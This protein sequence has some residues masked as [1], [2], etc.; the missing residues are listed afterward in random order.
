MN[1]IGNQGNGNRAAAQ[2]GFGLIELMVALLLG[3]IIAGGVVQVFYSTN[4]AYR[5]QQAL[6]LFDG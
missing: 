5:S 4:Q 1:G 2:R 6:Y 3:V